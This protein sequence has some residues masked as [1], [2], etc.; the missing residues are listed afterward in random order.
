MRR[1][2]RNFLSLIFLFLVVSCAQ[3]G[4]IS[5]GEKDIEP[6]V[7]ISSSPDTLS[8]NVPVDLK[9]IVLKFN[10][11][12]LLKDFIKN[13]IISP[14]IEPTPT[15][16]PQG[17]ADKK[18]KITFNDSLK[19]NTTYN[20]HFGKSLV[21]NNEGNVKKYFNYVFSTGNFIDSLKIEGQVFDPAQKQIPENIIV[22]LYEWDEKY[23]DS[24]ILSQ[25]PY[26]VGKVDSLGNFT[27]NHLKES[28]YRLIAFTDKVN[29][30]RVDLEEETMAFYP[31]KI[32]P[33]NTNQEITLELFPPRSY[34]RVNDV[35]Q[36][37]YGK[38]NFIMS[39]Q[40][41]EIEIL[42]INHEFKTAKIIHKPFSDTLQFWFDPVKDTIADKNKRLTFAVNHHEKSDTI[43]SNRYNNGVQPAL[44]L[45]SSSDVFVL[46]D[47]LKIRSNY[48]IQQIDSTLINLVEDTVKIS[49]N[50]QQKN[51]FEFD[52]KF[53]IRFEKNYKV[54]L[55]PGAVIDFFGQAN[56]TVNLG[57]RVDKERAYGNVKVIL[58]NKP[59]VPVWVQLLNKTGNVILSKYTI[60]NEVEFKRLKPGSYRLKMM[61]DE[62]ANGRWDTGDFFTNTQPE[63]IYLYAEELDVKAFWDIEETWILNGENQKGEE[64]DSPENKDK[65]KTDAPEEDAKLKEI[66][67]ST[68][69]SSALPPMQTD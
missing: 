39:G 63:Q 1:F 45:T 60:E 64:I 24:L 48:P 29:N 44:T 41:D 26:Y 30:T 55:L 56:D 52:L 57:M 35:V 34:F 36:D 67:D 13:I 15:F 50:I 21:D 68:I 18:V 62:N 66:S 37:G 16:Y 27:L 23:T 4:S 43:R 5:G 28:E 3:K 32:N 22:G 51:D 11:F 25:K 7:L 14:P 42:P 8:T 46:E 33:K 69:E 53:P 12:V 49:Y 20:I 65:T 47:Y 54:E 6:P 40:P 17:T 9:E 31:R 38:F 19:P 59:D 58:Q 61:V 10:E 2:L